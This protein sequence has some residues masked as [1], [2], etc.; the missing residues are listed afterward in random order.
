MTQKNTF[1]TIMA[2]FLFIGTVLPIKVDAVL[3][4][5]GNEITAIVPEYSVKKRIDSGTM[6]IT[7]NREQN[8]TV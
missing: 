5:N 1:K 8:I 6:S 3:R 4:I 7:I 2:T